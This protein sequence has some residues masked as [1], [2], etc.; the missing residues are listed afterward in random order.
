MYTYNLSIESTTESGCIKG[1]CGG[2]GVVK[3]TST[4]TID[5]DPDGEN[6]YFQ[7]LIKHLDTADVIVKADKP[8]KLYGNNSN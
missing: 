7:V 1:P 4:L 2:K 3:I 8:F 6:F 5:E